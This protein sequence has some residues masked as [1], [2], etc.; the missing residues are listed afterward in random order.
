MADIR[1]LSG[2]RIQQVIHTYTFILS[3]NAEIKANNLAY[4]MMQSSSRNTQS[5]R[6]I[7]GYKSAGTQYGKTISKPTNYN[8]SYCKP[9]Y[10]SSNTVLCTV[11][12]PVIQK[13]SIN[14]KWI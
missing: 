6:Y 7:T 5:N 3:T 2:P 8:H 13:M 14:L 1:C 12:K 4:D 10:L 11:Y 9:I